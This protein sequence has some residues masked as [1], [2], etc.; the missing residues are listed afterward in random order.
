MGVD[1]NL[2]DPDRYGKPSRGKAKPRLAPLIDTVP[3][4]AGPRWN[5]VT[6]KQHGVVHAFCDPKPGARKTTAMVAY[7]GITG[8]PLSFEPGEIVQGCKACVDRGAKP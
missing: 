1:N 6:K 2:F 4:A 8:V 5:L 3:V 7:C